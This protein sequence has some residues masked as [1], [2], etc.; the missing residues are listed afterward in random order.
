MARGEMK[1]A[2]KRFQERK[3]RLDDKHNEDQYWQ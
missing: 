2:V 3:V 1:A